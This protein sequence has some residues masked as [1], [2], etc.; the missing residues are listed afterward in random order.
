[1][2]NDTS[3]R[4]S[5]RRPPKKLIHVKSVEEIPDFRSD[6]EI[7]EWYQTHSTL[8]IADQLESLPAS[9]GGR[10]RPRLAA[11]RLRMRPKTA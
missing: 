6:D 7:A 11:R 3:A 9:V 10:L 5:R 2:K 4:D 1:M 8:L